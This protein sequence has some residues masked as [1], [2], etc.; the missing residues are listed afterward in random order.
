MGRLEKAYPIF[1]ILSETKTSILAILP[2][3]V[4]PAKMGGQK[5]I[6]LFYENLLKHFPLV[7]VGTKNN[8]IETDEVLKPL[9]L[10]AN[11]FLRYLDI[12]LYF[13]LKKII[14]EQKITHVII[15]H[16]YFGWL[17]WLLQATTEVQLTVRS[18]NIESLRF[19]STG[20]W[21]WGILWNY[22]KW[23]HRKASINF[24]ITQTDLN[25]AVKKYKIKA[26]SAHVITYGLA[27]N[28]PPAVDER[29]KAKLTLENKFG[30]T[31]AP[32]IIFF[33]GTLNYSPNIDAIKNIIEK[34]NPLLLHEVNFNYKIIICGKDLPE[35]LKGL[36]EAAYENINYAGFVPDIDLYFKGADIF[37]NP[38]VDGGGIKTKL[39]EA[40]GYNLTSI[41]YETGATGIPH[42]M[43]ADKLLLIKNNDASAFAKAVINASLTVT[44]SKEFYDYFSWEGIAEKAS[45]ILK[46]NNK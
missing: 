4:F 6:A 17:G 8:V 10:L 7:L 3:P 42:S 31:N 32:R 33:N 38:V 11:S 1:Y 24:F 14:K 36:N 25:Y 41:S 16:P 43:C 30:F 35:E 18:H 9:P 23:V 19:K 45:S 13:K 15:E 2:Y 28:R 44:T 37:I 39:V 46:K 29:K 21:W 26:S 34:I 40:L 20:K 27:F 12:S 5:A 22:E